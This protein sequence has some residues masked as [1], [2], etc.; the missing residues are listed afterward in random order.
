[1]VVVKNQSFLK[2]IAIGDRISI[3]TDEIKDDFEFEF[4]YFSFRKEKREGG[5]DIHLK[6]FG[7]YSQSEIPI[8][9]KADIKGCEE[10]FL[11]DDARYFMFTTW[12][13]RTT[14]LAIIKPVL[15]GHKKVKTFFSF[16][17]PSDKRLFL[18]KMGFQSVIT[19]AI[20]FLLFPFR[21]AVVEAWGEFILLTVAFLAFFASGFRKLC[22]IFSTIFWKSYAPPANQ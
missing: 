20:A 13:A 7:H 9:T 8:I 10:L 18:L 17:N 4:S 15:N 1:V 11:K 2:E 19:L 21:E 14:S 16:I 22:Y 3:N 6:E 5:F 12:T